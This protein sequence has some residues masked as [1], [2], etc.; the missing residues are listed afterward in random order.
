M[1]F[2]VAH[3]QMWNLKCSWTVSSQ[4]A[5]WF[6]EQITG[7]QGAHLVSMVLTRVDPCNCNG[8]HGGVRNEMVLNPA[9]H[10][11]GSA[12]RKKNGQPKDRWWT[13]MILAKDK[14][15]RMYSTQTHLLG[16]WKLFL[17]VAVAWQF[18]SEQLLF[19]R[20]WCKS[21]VNWYGQSCCFPKR[22]R[23]G[24]A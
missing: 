15:S 4:K 9:K 19:P 20:I 10:R 11:Q 5:H 18:C 21:M 3:V 22:H 13:F 1:L 14:S 23:E 24:E 7:R 6:E 2:W 17:P 12:S 8:H 16:C